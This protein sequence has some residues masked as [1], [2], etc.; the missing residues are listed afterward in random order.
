MSCVHVARTRKIWRSTKMA[1]QISKKR[2]VPC[3]KHCCIAH[4]DSRVF[5]IVLGTVVS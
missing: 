2:K 4:N 1:T 3:S 5:G